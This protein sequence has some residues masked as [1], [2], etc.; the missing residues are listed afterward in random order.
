MPRSSGRVKIEMSQ[1][2]ALVIGEV[3]EIADRF[4]ARA[5]P[6]TSQGE[7]LTDARMEFER[8]LK[9]AIMEEGGNG[10]VE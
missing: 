9:R 8:E 4:F 1:R 10:A 3:M 7:A 5:F 2:T 6:F